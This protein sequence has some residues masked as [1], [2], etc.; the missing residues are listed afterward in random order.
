MNETELFLNH[1]DF[2]S[3][4]QEILLWEFGIAQ[5]Q[6][7]YGSPS[8]SLPAETALFQ[9][10]R[11][12]AA[13]KNKSV[14]ERSFTVFLGDCGAQFELF[15]IGI[16][17]KTDSKISD[18]ITGCFENIRGFHSMEY[19]RIPYVPL[20]PK[21]RYDRG[22]VFE[23]TLDAARAGKFRKPDDITGGLDVRCRLWMSAE[24]AEMKERYCEPEAAH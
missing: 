21:Y 14:R 2:I 18:I 24:D 17:A 1:T 10:F 5:L 22:R 23:Y 20:V 8:Y 9:A 13:S 7:A 19:G 6:E 3:D 11:A 4:S 12:I 16:G 15:G